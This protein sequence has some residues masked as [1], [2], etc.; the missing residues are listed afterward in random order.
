MPM[1]LAIHPHNSF[2]QLTSSVWVPLIKMLP[3]S[4][5]E[6]WLL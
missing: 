2:W 1:G 3:K 4:W 5:W 6:Q